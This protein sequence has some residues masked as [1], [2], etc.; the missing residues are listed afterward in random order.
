MGG[1]RGIKRRDFLKRGGQGIVGAAFLGSVPLQAKRN[2][3]EKAQKEPPKRI[4]QRT[5]GRTGIKLPVLSMGVMNAS[6]P[7]L[8]RAALDSGIVHLD[9]AW[10]YQRGQNET[11]IGEV[12][13]GRPRDSFVIA[14][15][16]YENQDRTTGLFPAD[17]Q[18]ESFIE[19]FHTSLKRLQLDYVDILYLHNI[20]HPDSVTFAPYLEAML[21]LKKEGKVRHLGVS[22]HRNEPEII[23]KTTDCGHYDVILT[24]YNFRQ[25]HHA[26]IAEAV[27]YAAGKGMGIVGMKA[28]AGV[29]RDIKGDNKQ[30]NARAALKWALRNENF[31]TNIAGFTTFEQLENDLPVME[32]LTLTPGELLD[33]ENTRKLTGVFCQQCGS[34][35]SQCPHHL[36]IPDLMRGYMYA[37]GYRNLAAAREV[38]ENIDSSRL[39]CRD[40]TECRV[41]CSMGFDVR[42]RALAVARIRDIPYQFIG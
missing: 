29:V 42:E 7:D 21:K 23:R 27:D 17:A 26:E 6:N 14:T 36:E 9:T 24:S 8:V 10:I 37:R 35:V 13:K 31:H 16:I 41:S 5:L 4:I 32:D 40:C 18:S 34:C 30:L 39:Q 11:M 33:I 25:Q 19:K 15:K 1:N 28:I 20:S 2:P 12:V 38:L 22:T 3:L